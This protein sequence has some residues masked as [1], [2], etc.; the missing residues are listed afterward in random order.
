MDKEV[1]IHARTH[2]HTHTV[3]YYSAIKNETI[4]PFVTTWMDLE[5]IRL[6]DI[7][8]TEKDKYHIIMWNLKN[9]KELNTR[10]REHIGSYQR[11]GL[12]D[13]Q[14]GVKMGKRY[15]LPVIK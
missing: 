14:N 12:K 10:Y 4:L 6:T 7:S 11:Q 2:T 9:Y 8:Q 1:L 13:R 15:K 5:G 3:K